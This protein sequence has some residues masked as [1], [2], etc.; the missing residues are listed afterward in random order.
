MDK[1]AFLNG[2]AINW[3][4]RTNVECLAPFIVG[5]N[6]PWL[7]R[8]TQ[9]LLAQGYFVGLCVTWDLAVK[10]RFLNNPIAS[11]GLHS[12]IANYEINSK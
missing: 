4:N 7:E 9:L 1:N 6:M 12:L 8:S 5:A 10:V 3:V 2:C 11:I